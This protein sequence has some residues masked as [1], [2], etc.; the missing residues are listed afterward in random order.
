MDIVPESNQFERVTN[1][2]CQIRSQLSRIQNM[3]LTDRNPIEPNTNLILFITHFSQIGTLSGFRRIHG[4]DI[5][6]V[7]NPWIRDK[8]RTVFYY[9]LSINIIK[10]H[11]NMHLMV[12]K[13]C[14]DGYALDTST[15]ADLCETEIC[16]YTKDSNDFNLCCVRIIIYIYIL[17]F[18]FAKTTSPKFFWTIKITWI[19][20]CCSIF[21]LCRPN[22]KEFV[23]I[24]VTI[25]Y[26][27]FCCMFVRATFS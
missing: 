6:F 9:I 17:Y 1:L 18:F 23:H 24:A 19:T 11:V 5:V 25:T 10:N 21:W 12:E 7:W 20:H 13:T 27:R 4:F 16:D 2:V 26:L 14:G 3:G 15:E 8:L 22:I